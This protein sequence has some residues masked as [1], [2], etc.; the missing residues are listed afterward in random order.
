MD[1]MWQEYQ[2]NVAKM[3][4]NQLADDHLFGFEAG[5]DFQRW[6]IADLITNGYVPEEDMKTLF[7]HS[8]AR[9]FEQFNQLVSSA[10]AM[11]EKASYNNPLDGR[12]TLTF[13]SKILQPIS[14]LGEHSKDEAQTSHQ[15]RKVSRQMSNNCH[16]E[17][18]P[19][20]VVMKSGN[21]KQSPFWSTPQAKSSKKQMA[22]PA[23]DIKQR[24]KQKRKKDRKSKKEKV[25][26]EAKAQKAGEHEEN[27]ITSHALP[28]RPVLDGQASVSGPSVLREISSPFVSAITEAKGSLQL[29]QSSSTSLS[30]IGT[31]LDMT[32]SSL[33]ASDKGD[34]SEEIRAA[35]ENEEKIDHL[36]QART[37]AQIQPLK[38]T[39]KSRY[40]D[41]EDSC[42]PKAKVPRPP[43][44]IVPCIP[45]PRLD[46]PK[47]GLIQED[48]ASDPFRLLIAVTFL[49]RVKG[50][51]ALP[52]F[53]ELMSIYPTP[54]ALAKADTDDI[55]AM[56]KHLGL[57]TVRAAAIQKYARI[58]IDNPPKA[59]VR[60]DVKNYPA[61]D[62]RDDTQMGE[63][64]LFN[65]SSTRPSAWEIGHMTQGRY[66]IDSWRIFC[67]DVLLERA[68][69]WR[70]KGREGEFQPEWMR[71]LPEDKEL[72]ACLR[73]L[74]M[75]EGWE[76]NPR[77][78][79]REILPEA[80]RK[81]VDEGRVGYDDAGE[82]K[83][84]KEGLSLSNHS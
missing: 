7:R 59:G 24:E 17:L 78:G 64:D 70:G 5:N 39:A 43:R 63:G 51:H 54:E 62:N 41:N 50:K 46:A 14:S 36:S 52:V 30:N 31:G 66:A 81:A 75:Q 83:I 77:T 20:Q 38:R 2:A 10:N 34:N 48:L 21:D 29:Q 65:S 32:E 74:W 84:V 73:W 25:R 45:F 56:I 76:W 16:D 68:E 8:L 72:R 42:P 40:F 4:H 1:W 26:K 13:I 82:L 58:W 55:V 44:G 61:P 67:R 3:P 18:D 9:G 79:D 57:A 35:S 53:H 6:Y 28:M 69:D 11:R 71:V 47:F 60:Y 27:D 49:I 19:G 80:L 12:D 15:H 23:N 33:G 37:Q 22:Q